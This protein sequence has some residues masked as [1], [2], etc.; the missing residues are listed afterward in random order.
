MTTLSTV[1]SLS[2]DV[3]RSV[4]TAIDRNGDQQL[5]VGEFTAFLDRRVGGLTGGH[6]TGGLGS[7]ATAIGT[8]ADTTPQATLLATSQAPP[9][10]QAAAEEG[11]YAQIPGFDFG[12]LADSTHT[13]AKYTPAVRVFS[14]AIA[15]GNLQPGA[16][17][18]AR[19]VEY[20]KA[21][22]FANA[23]AE[24]DSID[25][26]DG[27]GPID[28]IRNFKSGREMGWWFNNQPAPSSDPAAVKGTAGRP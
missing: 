28:A 17:G 25:F 22:G 1:G 16:E 9:Q 21:H 14:Q 5:S 10:A 23:S 13:S 11:G 6:P 2:P 7:A 15:A 27:H 3:S 26:G 12:K 19:V 18:L 8:S 20:A 24:G 4:F